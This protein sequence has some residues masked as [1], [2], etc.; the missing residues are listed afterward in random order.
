MA[1]KESSTNCVQLFLK[2]SSSL[3]LKKSDLNLF[4]SGFV[5]E[6][7]AGF[8]SKIESVR[9]EFIKVFVQYIQMFKQYFKNL[10]QFC[11]L[12]DTE[13]IEKDFFENIKHIQVRNIKFLN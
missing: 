13:D 2:K 5:N 9:H 6:I 12:M 1:I 3:E 11:V 10:G 4:E 7:K 8:R